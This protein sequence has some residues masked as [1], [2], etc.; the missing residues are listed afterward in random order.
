MNRLVIRMTEYRDVDWTQAQQIVEN[1]IAD[2]LAIR[3]DRV[4]ATPWLYYT[5]YTN[6]EGVVINMWSCISYQLHAMP[7]KTLL[8][9]PTVVKPWELDDWEVNQIHTP[10]VIKQVQHSRIV[11]TKP[12]ADSPFAN[13][14]IG[15]WDE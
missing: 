13:E 8:G 12:V 6:N 15:G 2:D 11:K 1:A 5:P 7:E 14:Y 4:G 3:L 9:L 10:W